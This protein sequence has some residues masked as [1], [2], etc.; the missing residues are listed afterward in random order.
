MLFRLLEKDFFL[1]FFPLSSL[2]H[3]QSRLVVIEMIAI[4]GRIERSMLQGIPSSSARLADGGGKRSRGH[5]L[6][7]SLVL[8]SFFLYFCLL[9]SFCRLKRDEF[10]PRLNLPS[11][12][13]KQ[14]ADYFFLFSRHRSL[15]DQLE[16]LLFAYSD[17]LASRRTC[18]MI[19]WSTSQSQWRGIRH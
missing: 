6:P 16:N 11:R 8:F 7:D 18:S 17:P 5:L 10:I 15:M 3:V 9:D 2:I 19:I 13:N 14:K 1:F 12:E 4:T